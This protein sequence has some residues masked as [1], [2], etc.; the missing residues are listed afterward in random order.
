[1]STGPY[2][3]ED[4]AT[5]PAGCANQVARASVPVD[6]IQLKESEAAITTP[7][8]FTDA[9]P[10]C[11][12]RISENGCIDCCECPDGHALFQIPVLSRWNWAIVDCMRGVSFL[13]GW[14][15]WAAPSVLKLTGR[16]PTVQ[17][18][19]HIWTRTHRRLKHNNWFN[20]WISSDE[21]TLI[22]L[23]PVTSQGDRAKAKKFVAIL[24]SLSDNVRFN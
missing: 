20:L 13:Y 5:A 19:R 24:A 14:S 8:S 22:H 9:S 10:T 16:W 17:T 18:I 2:P 3:L 6:L 12:C 11:K 23:F 1:M 4:R 7:T 21:P 15:G